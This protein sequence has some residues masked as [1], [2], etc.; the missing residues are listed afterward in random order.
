MKYRANQW[1]NIIGLGTI[2]ALVGVVFLLRPKDSSAEV[3]PLA[4]ETMV[5]L[6]ADL[7]QTDAWV[8]RKGGPLKRRNEMRDEVY[9]EVLESYGLNRKTFG[10]VYAFYLNHPS[11]LDTVYGSMVVLMQGQIDS[12]KDNKFI[13]PPK[14]T[15]EADSPQTTI[16]PADSATHRPPD[17]ILKK[18]RSPLRK[19]RDA[20]Q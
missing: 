13:A 20:S 1:G 7:H 6:M 12:L 16:L 15:V 11:L 8:D 5:S 2:L 19:R 4:P 18:V 14:P 10:E 9:D 3:P 17:S